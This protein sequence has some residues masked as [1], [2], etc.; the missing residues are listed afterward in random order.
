MRMFAVLLTVGF[1]VL[2]AAPRAFAQTA[3][4]ASPSALDSA[5]QQH[6][7]ST[8]AERQMVQNLLNRADVKAVAAGAGIDIR[9]AATAVST[10]DPASLSEVASQARAVEQALAGG[11]SKITVNTTLVIIGLLILILI[12]VAVQ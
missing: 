3:H 11:Q 2:V 10:M 1:S 8:D 9:S 5:V 12:I 6:V 4:T 7:K